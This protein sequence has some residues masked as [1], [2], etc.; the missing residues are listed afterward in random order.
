MKVYIAGYTHHWSTRDVEDWYYQ[1]RYKKPSWD[2]KKKD[3][4]R[5]DK[6][7]DAFMDF[8]GYAV[9]LP[10]NRFK[11][12]LPRP[13]YIKIDNYDVWS[14]DSTLALIILPMLIKLRDNKMGAPFTDDEDVPEELRSTAAEPKENDYDT[15]SN[16]FKRWDWILNEM[17]WAFTQINDDDDEA[18]YRSGN[19][20]VMWQ[21]VDKD[22]N[23][24]GEPYKMG[25]RSKNPD[26]E[27]AEFTQ[28][29]DGPKH[30]FKTDY[31][32]LNLHWA[33]IKN[34]T[35]LFGK[36]YQALWD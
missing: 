24:I 5:F 19:M 28:M 30:T 7:F 3:K 6:F 32:G 17:I 25:E 16:H 33:R 15:D 11:N 23:K 31:E 35:R 12:L 13:T 2:V 1:L 29:I 22:G 14:M 36:Y 26:A 8:W 21:A 9:C 10:V 4:N 20:D 34:G 18:P 27:E